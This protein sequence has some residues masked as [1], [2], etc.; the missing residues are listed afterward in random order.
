MWK[1]LAIAIAALFSQ[2]AAAQLPLIQREQRLHLPP[3][4]APQVSAE[5]PVLF[6]QRVATDGR[7]AVVTVDQGRA[8]YSYFRNTNGEWVYEGELVA[9]S[10]YTSYGAAVLGNTAL[11]QSV[12]NDEPVAFV[13]VRSGGTWAHTQTLTDVDFPEH[14][15]NYVALGANFAVLGNRHADDMKGA[16]FVYSKVGS[17]SYVFSTKLAPPDAVE[18]TM[19]GLN[20]VAQGNTFAVSAAGGAMVIVYENNGGVWSEQA[21]LQ[22]TDGKLAYV[23]FGYSGNTIVLT[24]DSANPVVFTRTNGAWSQSQALVHPYDPQGRLDYSVALDGRRLIVANRGSDTA[25]LYERHQGSWT[26][27]AELKGVTV[28]AC[29]GSFSALPVSV[30]GRYAFVSCPTHATPNPVFEGRV[31]VYKLPELP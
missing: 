30:Q 3:D 2:L 9:P 4:P 24:S 5:L 29:S 7:R 25:F 19:L 26:A 31:R 11:V 12:V 27:Q 20:P 13:F 23:T 17:G 28:N 22:R 21:R 15:T 6:G 1:C 8:A 18:G 10:G 16:A 14:G